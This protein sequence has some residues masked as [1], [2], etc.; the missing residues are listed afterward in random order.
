[1]LN[2]TETE[3][4]LLFHPIQSAGPIPTVCD[5][6]GVYPYESFVETAERPSLIKVKMIIMENS[7]LKVKICPDL[8]GRFSLYLIKQVTKKFYT[9]PVL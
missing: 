6:D 5:P 8:G 4:L 7:S 3:E 1:M 2:L 9:I